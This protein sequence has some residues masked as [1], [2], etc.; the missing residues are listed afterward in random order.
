MII[1]A[2][3]RHI[4]I[5]VDRMLQPAASYEWPDETVTRVGTLF[6]TT[7]HKDGGYCDQSTATVVES[8]SRLFGDRT[9]DDACG[10][11]DRCGQGAWR[12]VEESNRCNGLRVYAVCGCNKVRLPDTGQSAHVIGGSRFTRPASNSRRTLLN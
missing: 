4:C 2:M 1:P 3:S 7:T 11:F 8:W 9:S 12:I 5:A 6:N 10:K